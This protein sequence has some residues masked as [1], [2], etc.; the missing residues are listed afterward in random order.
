M[1][2]TTLS[3]KLSLNLLIYSSTGEKKNTSGLFIKIEKTV[4]QL[5]IQINKQMTQFTQNTN[6]FNSAK[7]KITSIKTIIAAM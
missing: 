4:L 3:S 6:D 7:V 2:G 5:K 1:Y